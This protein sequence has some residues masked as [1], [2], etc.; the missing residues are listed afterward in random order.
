MLVREFLTR[1]FPLKCVR[2]VVGMKVALAFWG[3]TRSLS[4]T[5]DS[6]H[7]N[8]L[9]VLRANGIE[10]TIFL[11]TYTLTNPLT[12]PRAKEVN[13]VLNPTEYELLK[14]DFFEV[15]N[16]EEVKTRL[17]LTKYRTHRDIWKT[18]YAL[19]D[20]Y[21]CAMWS[22]KQVTK[23]IQESKMEFDCIIF[24]RPD[25]RYLNPLKVEW[26]RSVHSSNVFIPNFQKVNQMNDRFSIT[27]YENGIR[28]GNIF[29]GI[30]E[31][32]QSKSIHSETI[33][34]LFIKKT[35][36]LNIKYIPF[37]FNRVRANGY[38]SPDITEQMLKSVGIPPPTKDH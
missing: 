18:K 26:L 11:H 30:L 7:K 2:I 28:I 3:I 21:I 23:L 33:L 5:L 22:K 9:D 38:E 1:Q 4:I 29:D 27:N 8:V 24:L 19:V 16:Q 17:E 6:I 34:F 37:F 25:V 15:E 10:Y 35:L 31:Y 32:S 36:K 13:C 12:N 14:P 20:N